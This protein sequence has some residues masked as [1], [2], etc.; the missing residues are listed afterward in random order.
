MRMFMS[1]ISSSGIAVGICCGTYF[2]IVH[3]MHDRVPY[4]A[5]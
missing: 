1:G 2:A 5:L 3:T 4:L